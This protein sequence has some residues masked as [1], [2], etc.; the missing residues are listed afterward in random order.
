MKK[1]Y[2][3]RLSTAIGIGI[4]LNNPVAFS[5]GSIRCPAPEDVQRI[6]ISKNDLQMKKA[7]VRTCCTASGFPYMEEGEWIFQ[8]EGQFNT[9]NIWQFSLKENA[10]SVEEAYQKI[11]D[12]HTK[13]IGR[14]W[15][16]SYFGHWYCEYDGSGHLSMDLKQA[17]L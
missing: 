4:T 8:V 16:E 7:P 12:S 6:I 2:I 11:M 3:N 17:S 9:E 13:N 5:N 15:L 1:K 10:L 14:A